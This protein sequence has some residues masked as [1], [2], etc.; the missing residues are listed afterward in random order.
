MLEV[1]VSGN[2]NAT[3]LQVPAAMITFALGFVDQSARE[4]FMVYHGK[5][6]AH[7][8]RRRRLVSSL[9]PAGDAYPPG[10]MAGGKGPTFVHGP[11]NPILP[12]RGRFFDGLRA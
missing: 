6:L 2:I 1:W 10:A 12:A 8:R 5:T 7:H 11:A 3:R 4:F 9:A